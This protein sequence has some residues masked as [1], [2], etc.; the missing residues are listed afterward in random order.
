MNKMAVILLRGDEAPLAE[1]YLLASCHPLESEIKLTV[2]TKEPFTYGFKNSTNSLQTICP[3]GCE[4][5]S[6]Q[7]LTLIS[8]TI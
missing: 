1:P 3:S 5:F 7:V 2:S 8:C 4:Y 6:Q